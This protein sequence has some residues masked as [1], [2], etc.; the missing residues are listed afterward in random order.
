[1]KIIIAASSGISLVNFRGNLIREI[2]RRGHEVYCISCENDDATRTSVEGLGAHYIYIPMSRT[3]TNILE[4]LKTIIAFWKVISDTKP[5]IYFAYMSKPITYGG[6]VARICKVPHINLLVNGLEIAFYRNDFK[7]KIIRFVLKTC[8]RFACRGAE[9]V[10]FQNPD[11]LNVFNTLGIVQKEPCTIVN[12]SG[13]DMKYFDKRP[14]PEEPCVL[15]IARL[16]WSKGIREY[17]QA[18]EIVKE[19]KPNVRFILVGGLDQNQESLTEDELWHY[20]DSSAVEYAGYADDVRQYIEESSIFVL[21]SYHEGTPR[22]V[23][24]AM[25]MGRPIITTNAPGCRETVI[26]GYNGYLVEVK[27]HTQLAEKIETLCRDSELRATMGNHSYMLCAEKYDVK[28]V[29]E[30]MIN[31]MNLL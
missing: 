7:S 8:Y 17:L 30:V 19:K 15:M 29:N 25:S 6:A 31:K 1:M 13:V 26:D 11:D 9:N 24:E 22:S 20:V 16:I 10:F 21:P 4:D 23:L 14:L 27:N 5:D 3:G 2:V 12:G 18:A 28:L